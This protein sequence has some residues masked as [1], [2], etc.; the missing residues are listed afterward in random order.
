MQLQRRLLSIYTRSQM[1]SRPRWDH[2]VAST[3]VFMSIHA[4]PI[5][6][7]E[8]RAR[9]S[10]PRAASNGL[11]CRHG[12]SPPHFSDAPPLLLLGHIIMTRTY[13]RPV[14]AFWP[15]V[16]RRRAAFPIASTRCGA[17]C[18]RVSVTNMTA[19]SGPRVDSKCLIEA[20]VASAWGCAV[21]A[22]RSAFPE[23]KSIPSQGDR[24]SGSGARY[25]QR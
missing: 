3:A 11:P 13:S 22:A 4:F 5:L 24:P 6:E 9:S 25:Q 15:G 20:V 12:P 1:R 18:C 17:V 23:E 21:R 2:P 7:C 14:S 8:S 16:A 19:V 10:Q